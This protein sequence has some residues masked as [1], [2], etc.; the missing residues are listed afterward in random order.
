MGTL[1]KEIV[2]QGYKQK[3]SMVKSLAKA[4]NGQKT[5]AKFGPERVRQDP[6]EAQTIK[7]AVMKGDLG[8]PNVVVIPDAELARMRKEA[9]IVTVDE[10]LQQKKI[11]EEQR[12][13]QQAAAVAKKKKMMELEELKRQ[14]ADLTDLEKEQ[15]AETADV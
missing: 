6:K 3:M 7:Q 9:V 11:M 15:K 8:N 13:K 14:Q 1:I 10:Q 4:R 12:E 5:N 2:T